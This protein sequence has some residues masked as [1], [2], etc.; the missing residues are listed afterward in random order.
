[1]DLGYLAVMEIGGGRRMG[2]TADA[3]Q[4]ETRS[5]TGWAPARIVAYADVR[6]AYRYEVTDWSPLAVGFLAW[7]GAVVLGAVAAVMAQWSPVVIG[8]VLFLVTLAAAALVGLRIAR[9]P[10]RLLRIETKFGT[11]V[12]PDRAPGLYSLLAA[13][14]SSARAAAGAVAEPEPGPAG[15]APAA[16][17]PGPLAPPALETPTPADPEP[18]TELAPDYEPSPSPSPGSADEGAS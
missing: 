14:L 17:T 7:V 8:I 9:V 10:R 11:L 16:T 18:R 4:V 5:P 2:L 3:L 12:V 15:A 13:Q 1:V 6:A